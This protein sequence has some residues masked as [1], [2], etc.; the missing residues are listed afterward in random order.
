MVQPLASLAELL[1]GS[2]SLRLLLHS[3]LPVLVSRPRLCGPR[4]QRLL[5]PS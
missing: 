1:L 2:E 4:H 3:P 5:A